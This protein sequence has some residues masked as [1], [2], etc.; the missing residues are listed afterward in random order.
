M[1]IS[2]TGM[3]CISPAGKNCEVTWDGLLGDDQ[4]E[5]TG[6][7]ETG[8]TTFNAPLDPKYDSSGKLYRSIE[9]LNQALEEALINAGL[10]EIPDLCKVGVCIGTTSASFLND[11]DFHRKLREHLIEEEPVKRFFACN[12]AEYIKEKLCL[13]GPA[14]TVL[15]ACASGTDAIGVAMA[16]LNGGICDIVIAELGLVWSARITELDEVYESGAVK[17]IPRFGDGSLTLREF[18]RREMR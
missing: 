15:N 13:S 6:T 2:I 4:P 18:I 9:L 16:W 10:N 8:Q 14:M 17:Y 3:G 12:P 7:S 1:S 11:M 5:L